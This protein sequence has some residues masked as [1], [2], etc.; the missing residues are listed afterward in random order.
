[1][2]EAEAL[3]KEVLLLLEIWRDYRA[4]T[5]TQEE[6]EGCPSQPMHALSC[7]SNVPSHPSH[8]AATK[9]H[10]AASHEAASKAPEAPGPKLKILPEP[11]EIR[12]RLRLEIKFFVE[13][14]ADIK[15]V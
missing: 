1:V 14:L 9:L 7:H 4:E 5:N 3:H 11:P 10:E 8:P 2:D 12:E 13:N 15:C 6:G